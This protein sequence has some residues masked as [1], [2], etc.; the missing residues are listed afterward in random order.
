MER[1]F[2]RRDVLASMGSGTHTSSAGDDRGSS[3]GGAFTSG[4]YAKREPTS[5]AAAALSK[6]PPVA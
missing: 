1:T 2:N 5:F 4:A 6:F 3:A